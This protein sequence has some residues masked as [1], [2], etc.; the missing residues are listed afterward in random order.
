MNTPKDTPYSS[1]V[2]SNIPSLAPL[3]SGVIV[4]KDKYHVI[5]NPED[6]SVYNSSYIHD[7]NSG[8]SIEIAR[9]EVTMEESGDSAEISLGVLRDDSGTQKI[10]SV[11][12]SSPS[13][14]KISSLQSSI[15]D[16]CNL[17]ID[18]SGISWD[19]N[20]ACLYLSSNKRFRI[21]YVESDEFQPARLSIQGY[22]DSISNYVT[23]AEFFTT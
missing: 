21:K 8:E 17:K 13:T 23:K 5:Q 20:D 18:G 16:M 11:I 2:I 6:E 19:K 3:T 1:T 4:H 15:N 9:E 12:K 22:S 10:Q 14:T 7:E